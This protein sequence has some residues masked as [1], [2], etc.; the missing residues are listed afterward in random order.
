DQLRVTVIATG[1][2]LNN[3]QSS[4]DFGVD[5]V[6]R[7]VPQRRDPAAIEAYPGADGNMT[8]PGSAAMEPSEP[9]VPFEPSVLDDDYIPDFLKRDF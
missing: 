1:F 7:N 6:G 5:G 4:M 3:S 9:G 8:A 2:S